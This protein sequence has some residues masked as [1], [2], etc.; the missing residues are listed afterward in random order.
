VLIPFLTDPVFTTKAGGHSFLKCLDIEAQ[1]LN[2]EQ[3]R[4]SFLDEKLTKL[5]NLYF[6]QFSFVKILVEFNELLARNGDL[7]SNLDL[8]VHL[9]FLLAYSRQTDKDSIVGQHLSINTQELLKGIKAKLRKANGTKTDSYIA[10]HLIQAFFSLSEINFESVD[11]DLLLAL[12]DNVNPDGENIILIIDLVLSRCGKKS[13]ARFMTWLFERFVSLADKDL[14]CLVK[15]M[16][17][18]TC[19]IARYF[20]LIRL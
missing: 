16:T 4:A 15:F 13:K 11:E 12:I 17:L 19:F 3:L 1:Y 6:S 20:L 18:A 7:A 2:C 9:R 14:G 5:M 8:C 10:Y